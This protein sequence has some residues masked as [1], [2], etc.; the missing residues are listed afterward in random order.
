MYHHYFP[1]C[2]DFGLDVHRDR[3]VLNL[4]KQNPQRGR[5]QWAKP[6]N[7]RAFRQGILKKISKKTSP[8]LFNFLEPKNKNKIFS[9]KTYFLSKNSQEFD[10]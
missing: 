7:Y 9:A 10:D 1:G 3:H 6:R 5:Q 2:L 8:K 4:G